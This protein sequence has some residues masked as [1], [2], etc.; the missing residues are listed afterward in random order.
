LLPSQG[1]VPTLSSSDVLLIPVGAVDGTARIALLVVVVLLIAIVAAVAALAVIM[2]R[3]TGRPAPPAAVGAVPSTRLAAASGRPPRPKRATSQGAGAGLAIATSGGSGMVCPTCR[4][5]YAG[6]TYCTRDARRLVPAEE[7]L[8]G[9]RSAGGVCVSCR[10]AYEP[11]LRRC[12]HDG[13]ELV[14]VG[15]A[16]ALRGKKPDGAPTGVMAQLCPACRQ[17]FDLAA[18]FCGHD[19]TE[20]V[21]IN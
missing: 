17:V 11:G 5:E 21:V 12:P 19:G 10:R 18:R 14:P 7:M 15:V 6:L 13:G 1:D 4:T 3:R 20:L 9:G 16:I 8:S 2:R